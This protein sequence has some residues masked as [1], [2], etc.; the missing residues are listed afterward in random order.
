MK[1]ADNAGNA[2][3]AHEYSSSRAE[4]PGDLQKDGWN[5]LDE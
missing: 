2:L 3:S 4:T 1:T 5:V